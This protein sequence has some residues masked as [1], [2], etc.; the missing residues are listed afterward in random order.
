MVIYVYPCRNIVLFILKDKKWQ[1]FKTS[2]QTLLQERSIHLDS[3]T[4]FTW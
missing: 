1:L 3:Y 2:Q 4:P